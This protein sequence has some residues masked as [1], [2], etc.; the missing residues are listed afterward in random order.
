M[1]DGQAL[2]LLRS[3]PPHPLRHTVPSG[4]SAGEKAGSYTP[5]SISGLVIKFGFVVETS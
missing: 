5:S 4:F 3:T 2:P 1:S